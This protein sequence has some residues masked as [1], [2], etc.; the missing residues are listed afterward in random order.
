[1]K[2]KFLLLFVI[3]FFVCSG[4]GLTNNIKLISK[5]ETIYN[6]N[7]I[8]YIPSKKESKILIYIISPGG[9]KK[10]ALSYINIWKGIANNNNFVLASSMDWSQETIL[11]S[12]KEIKNKYG[13][14]KIFITGFS[15]GGYNACHFGL[16]N[17]NLING[18]IPMGAFCSDDDIGEKIDNKTPILIVVGEKDT[19]ARGDD[20]KMIDENNLRLNKF[21]I[22]PEVITIPGIG[23]VF[24]KNALPQVTE[25]INNNLKY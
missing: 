22:Y 17:S 20:L 23:H 4:C 21:G 19:W 1:M 24:P 13:I 16:K 5:S 8:L 10:E 15:N 18:I 2:N 25:W 7:Y 14:E 3:V 9:E 12:I 6:K 11:E